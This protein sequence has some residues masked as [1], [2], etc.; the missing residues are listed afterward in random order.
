MP[1][2]VKSTAGSVAHASKGQ[3]GLQEVFD[4]C[5]RKTRANIRLYAQ[6]PSRS[7]AWDE[8]GHY[9]NFDQGFFDIG[10][11]T[12]S[13]FTG[14]ALIA[15]SQTE[16]GSI[17][18]QVLSLASRYREKVVRYR[19]DTHHD[20]GFL[21]MLYSVALHRLTADRQHRRDALLAADLLA[22]R[23]NS[24][25]GFI[26]A[27]GRMGTSHLE[28]VAII[29]SLM[30][31]PLLYWASLES[32]DR[33]YH[34][35][36]ER[37][38]NT[39]LTYFVRPDDTVFHACRFDPETGGPIGGD[40]YCGYGVDSQWARGMA[41]AVYGF[42]LSHRYTGDQRYQDAAVRIAL[43]FIQHLDREGV[44]VWD[45]R[46]PE[47]EPRLRDSS[48]AAVGLC[49]IQELLR[50]GVA[51]S[52]LEEARQLLLGR[53]TSPDYFDADPRCSGL[54]KHAQ[55]GDGVGRARSCYTS[56]GDYFLMEALAREVALEQVI[57]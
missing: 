42:S 19:Q 27:W 47:G 39:S 18:R 20:L 38:A 1:S 52:E 6:D 46:L 53:L 41:W 34:M 10:N 54:L 4:V 8:S 11:W 31:L 12:S 9:A 35:I 33:T 7:W 17:M 29:D 32:G 3:R 51:D 40:N 48:A 14:M 50:Q 57:W 44:P 22:Q 24:I 43:Q 15:W 49:G 2:E 36:A 55:V 56:W 13:F 23:F 5:V 28:D 30:N 21:Y 26:R 37:H 25:G 45:L 16:D